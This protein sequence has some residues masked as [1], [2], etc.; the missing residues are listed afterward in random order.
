M[1]KFI[2]IL[3]MVLIAA[4]IYGQDVT[5][6]SVASYTNSLTAARDTIIIYTVPNIP[7]W[8]L[9]AKSTGIDTMTVDVLDPLGNWVRKSL[10]GQSS[11]VLG[12]EFTQIIATTTAA[13]YLIGDIDIMAI[14]LICPDASAALTFYLKGIEKSGGL[15][16]G[17]TNQSDGSQRSLVVNGANEIIGVQ[18]KPFYVTPDYSY[19]KS[20]DTW[21][22]AADTS[23]YNFGNT[24]LKAYVTIYDTSA[25]ADT[26]IFEYYSYAKNAYTSQAVGFMDISTNLLESDN[27]LIIVG[28]TLAKKY[29]VNNLRPGQIRIRPKTITGRAAIKTKRIV[30]EGIN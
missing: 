11:S 8:K 29:E 16:V 24:Y 7:Y 23:I 2:I 18:T 22:A 9:S 12:D 10:I 3:L 14:R 6:T 27:T 30:F 28:G 26:L 13:D 21:G 4:S 25:T 5:V 15:V 20:T 17:S 1:K 19:I